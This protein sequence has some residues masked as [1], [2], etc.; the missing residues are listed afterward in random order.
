MLTPE[1]VRGILLPVDTD[2]LIEHGIDSDSDALEE[3]FYTD[4]NGMY[5]YQRVMDAETFT[6]FNGLLIHFSEDDPD[7]IE[8]YAQMKDGY[9]LD[10]IEFYKSGALYSY[11]RHDDKEHYYYSWHENGTLS[12]FAVWHRRDEREYVRG[13]YYDETGRLI[14]QS[15]RCEIKATYEPDAADSPFDFTFHENGEF[16]KI[17]LKAPTTKDFYT[18]IE[19]DPDGYPVRIS[20]NPHYTEESLDVAR[21]STHH[22]HKTY[23]EKNFRVRDGLYEYYDHTI[24][25]WRI[26]NGD[27]LYRDGKNG[28]RIL[29]YY[30]GRQCGGQDFYYPHGLIKETFCI[31]SHGE[32]RRHIHWHPN[33]I[34]REATVYSHYAPMLH[35]TFDEKGNLRSSQLYSEVFRTVRK[36]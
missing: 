2:Y 22:W 32:Y 5:H 18:G 1:E 11:K 12:Q 16:R 6:P 25:T 21:E 36:K 17:T 7:R 24:Q 13:R 9:P 20:V 19:L 15:V 33:G 30:N 26:L 31:D 4:N 14:R 28:D 10:D 8:G 35:V 27:V 34:M 23:D 29:S 3:G